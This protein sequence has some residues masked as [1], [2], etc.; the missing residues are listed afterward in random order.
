MLKTKNALKKTSIIGKSLEVL[1]GLVLIIV[2]IC[3]DVAKANP[4]D[5]SR[6]FGG[7]GLDMSFSI[8]L[9]LSIGELLLVIFN[10]RRIAAIISI[11][12]TLLCVLIMA[13]LSWYTFDEGWLANDPYPDTIASTHTAYAVSYIFAIFG[14]IALAFDIAIAFIPKKPKEDEKMPESDGESL[15]D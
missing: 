5:N 3:Y 9:L 8:Y 2:I 12:K 4:N 7:T 14:F 10:H 1:V 11:V 13:V 6:V 15:S